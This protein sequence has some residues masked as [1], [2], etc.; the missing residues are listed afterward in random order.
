M[1]NAAIRET[2]NLPTEGIEHAVVNPPG[3]DLPRLRCFLL[4]K[5][6]DPAEQNFGRVQSWCMEDLRESWYDLDKDYSRAASR[7]A[8]PQLLGEINILRD[9]L[10]A[11]ERFGLLVSNQAFAQALLGKFEAGSEQS[12]EQRFERILRLIM[13]EHCGYAF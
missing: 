13:M 11:E 5:H 12:L 9:P 1:T 10:R 7:V 3:V 6:E 8:I 2:A 4:F